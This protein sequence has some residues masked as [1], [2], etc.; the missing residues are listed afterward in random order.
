MHTNQGTVELSAVR[1]ARW[2]NDE[3]VVSHV[4]PTLLLTLQLFLHSLN[5]FSSPI[6]NSL[7]PDSDR[8]GGCH[9]SLPNQ[10][11]NPGNA[12]SQ[13]FSQFRCG[14]HLITSISHRPVCVFSR[15]HLFCLSLAN[16]SYVSLRPQ[17]N[18]PTIDD[19][20]FG[21]FHFPLSNPAHKGSQRYPGKMGR[22]PSWVFHGVIYMP[23]GIGVS[24]K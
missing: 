19:C 12:N 7:F 21:R 16:P 14:F 10:G 23:S 20:E 13:Y 3:I 2:V 15:F 17:A 11:P 6:C 1:V 5:I 4:L 8:L 22:L 18:R 24:S 9:L